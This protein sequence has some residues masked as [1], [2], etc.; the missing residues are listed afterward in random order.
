MGD[1]NTILESQ[2]VIGIEED[3]YL[4]FDEAVADLIEFEVSEEGAIFHDIANNVDLE[5]ATEVFDTGRT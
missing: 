2:D 4:L 5:S 3:A 1:E